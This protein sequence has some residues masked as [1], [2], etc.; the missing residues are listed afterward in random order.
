VDKEF[1][2]KRLQVM[3]TEAQ[4]DLFLRAARRSGVSVGEFMRKAGENMAKTAGDG[5]DDLVGRVDHVLEI[6]EG[7]CNE[8]QALKER[9]AQLERAMELPLARVSRIRG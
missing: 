6:S 3:V 4:E 2:K 1:K 5:V 9:L 7:L 8:N